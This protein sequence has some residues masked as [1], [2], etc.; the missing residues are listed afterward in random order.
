MVEGK[1][2]LD[3]A[4]AWL[5]TGWAA[6]VAG[7]LAWHSRLAQKGARGFIS[8]E[9]AWE[10]PTVLFGYYLGLGVATWLGLK[11]GPVVNGV[12]LVV[13]YLGPGGVTVGAQM[14]WKHMDR[15]KFDL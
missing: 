4:V 8:W 6:A 2:I 1:T 15:Q 11:A 10:I 12:I 13:A 5:A 14:W 3:E 7:R 9:L